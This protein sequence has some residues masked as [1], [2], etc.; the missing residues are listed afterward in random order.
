MNDFKQELEAMEAIYNEK[1]S[2]EKRIE[3]LLAKF[4]DDQQFRITKSVYDRIRADKNK[5]Q[6][7]RKREVAA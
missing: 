4:D 1:T 2:S 7:G 5:P 3:S 6:L